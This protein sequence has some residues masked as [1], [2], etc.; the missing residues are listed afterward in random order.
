MIYANATLILYPSLESTCQLP[1]QT[2]CL[3]HETNNAHTKEEQM[4]G[5]IRLKCVGEEGKKKNRRG[6]QI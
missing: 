2:L 5:G 3:G 6:N 1:A 4:K